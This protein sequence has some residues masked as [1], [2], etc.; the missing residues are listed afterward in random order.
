MQKKLSGF[1]Y[2]KTTAIII[3]ILL[4]LAFLVLSIWRMAN[5]F[6]YVYLALLFIS[7]IVLVWL[8]N[9][10]TNPSYKLAWAIP[11]LALPVFGGIFYLLFGTS[12]VSSRLKKNMLLQQKFKT[13]YLTQNT[14]VWE[15]AQKEPAHIVSQMCYLKNAG[16][17]LYRDEG[18]CYF[19]LGDLKFPK[20]L[21]ELNKAKKYIFL[22]YFIIANGTMWQSVLSILK[23]KV[24]QGVEVR[25]IFDDCG[26]L[27][28]LPPNHEKELRDAGIK[29]R[30]FN[31]L[32]PS[33]T[34]TM[35]NRDHRKILIIDG[36]VGFT[37]GVNIGDEYINKIS[38]HGHWKDSAIMLEGQAVNTLISLFLEM[39]NLI[40][41]SDEDVQ[42]YYNQNPCE[43]H[44]SGYIQPYSSDPLSEDTVGENVYLNLIA[45]ANR[46]IFILTPYL[47]IDNELTTALCLAAKN[48]VSVNIVTPH[49]ADK[50]YVHLMTVS[51][52]PKLIK[53]GVNIYE[54]TP[55]F[56]HSKVFSVDGEI[57]SVG[58]INMDYRSL[59]LH[60][61][62]GV[63]LYRTETAKAI[64]ED[65]KNVVK[66]SQKITPEDCKKVRWYHRLFQ[67]LTR[68]FSPLM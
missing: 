66:V 20:M 47:I 34:I 59:Y 14:Q 17:P 3:L 39:W 68:V 44:C 35:N 8:I 56:V 62:C 22:E 58:T 23:D 9:S 46:E 40:S 2:R 53:A 1:F 21:A 60:F 26:S 5:Y 11:I 18:S 27:G 7:L 67:Q 31:P 54:Y 48:G 51:S 45:K 32:H 6:P 29:C 42:H 24:K 52:Y 25:V 63:V 38:V 61:E 43:N 10:D 28:L 65:C 36:T 30:V 4:Q 19:P 57:A 49:M 16:Y 50:W 12:K 55:G 13:Q 41:P 37:G 15:D 64:Y 33:L